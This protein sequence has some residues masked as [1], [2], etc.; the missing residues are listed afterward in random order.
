MNPRIE[1]TLY[2]DP[3]AAVPAGFCPRCGGAVYKPSLYCL[4]CDQSC[5][6]IT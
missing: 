6:D 2:I 5:H 4:R 3:Q 1:A